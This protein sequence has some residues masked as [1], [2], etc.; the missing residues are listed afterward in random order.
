MEHFKEQL[1]IFLLNLFAICGTGFGVGIIITSQQSLL[2]YMCGIIMLAAGLYLLHIIVIKTV[3]E[4]KIMLESMDLDK[5]MIMFGE[6]AKGQSF[7]IKNTNFGFGNKS[8][9][10]INIKK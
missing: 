5:I 3:E 9:T 8:V 6:S 1:N 7:I 4:L 2:G 10:N